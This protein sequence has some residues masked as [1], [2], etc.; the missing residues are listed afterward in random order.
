[1]VF[2]PARDHGSTIPGSFHIAGYLA[3]D[4][5][6]LGALA[7]AVLVYGR[8]W[9]QARLAGPRMAHPL[10]K[11]VLFN[12]GL[13]AVAGGVLSPL[14]HLGDEVLW[15]NFAGFL[16]ITMVGAPLLLLGSPLTLAFK[17]SA[18]QGRTRLRRLYR[19]WPVVAV[20]FPVASWLAF[21]VLTYA[22][23][24]TRL[25][26]LAA[27]HRLLREV[28]QVSLL[29]VALCFWMPA[30]AADP[31]RW[32]MAHPLRALY[33]V[34]EMTHKGLF[35][36][37]FLSMAHPF[38]AGFASRLPSWT[39]LTPMGDQRFAILVLWLGG[40]VIFVAALGGIVVR[41]VQYERRNAHRTDWHLSL[42]REARKR[43]QAALDQ[44][45][46]KG[47]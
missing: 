38:H 15:I 2:S 4:V 23:Q 27:E 16:L 18:R 14:S 1:M 35:G 47:V 31:L 28:Q 32:R 36:G 45:F 39:G 41:W 9:R 44:V 43:R 10:W 11:L 19:S 46:T 37:M 26:D 8:A 3:W 42:V 17:V 29:G 12:A 5:F 33:V 25:T 6:W 24:F 30:L 20:T 34:V 13:L 7:G 40:N 22:W 21:A